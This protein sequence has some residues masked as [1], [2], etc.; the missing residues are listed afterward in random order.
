MR[1]LLFDVDGTL[2]L[3]GGAGL[4]GMTRAIER[5]FGVPNAL[6]R[7]PV[8]GRTDP[9]ILVDALH[10]AGIAVTDGQAARFPDV[11]LPMLAEEMRRP[12]PAEA[13]PSQHGLHKGPLPGVTHLVTALEARR[14][15]FLALLTGNYSGGARI[16]LDHFGLWRPFRCGAFGEDAALR[17]ELVPIAIARAR[18]LGCPDVSPDEVVVIG[19]TP[20]DV[21]CAARAGVR[22]L[23]VATGGYSASTLCAAGAD[24]VVETLEH[25]EQI[26]GWLTGTMDGE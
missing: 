12:V 13:H 19:D 25:T 4:R 26:V 23:A 8:A 20:L 6:E 22:S 9:A 17:H 11:Y 14:D 18:A 10:R 24:H 16:K 3:T 1:L 2:V 21:E 5:I 15:V 7:V